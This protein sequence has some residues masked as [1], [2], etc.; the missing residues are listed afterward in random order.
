MT[1]N[2]RMEIMAAAK[3]VEAL[4]GPLRVVSD[5]TYV[6]NCFRKKWYVTWHRERL[7]EQ[8]SASRSRTVSSGSR[9]STRCSPAATSRSTG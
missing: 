4:A 7:E 3:A 6:V 8:L 5:S 1:T 2:Q 9:S